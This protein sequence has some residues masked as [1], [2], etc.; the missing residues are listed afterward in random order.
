M[1][2]LGL[3][4]LLWLLAP[5]RPCLASRAPLHPHDGEATVADLVLSALERATAFL[6]RRLREVNLD[7][8]L[9]FRVLE[10]QLGGVREQWARDPGMRPLGLRAEK[11]AEELAGLLQGATRYLEQSDAQYLREFRPTLLPGFWRLPRVW[12]LTNASLAY[13]TLEKQDS[14]SE[15]QSDACLAQLLG[16]GVD[17]SQPCA[18]SDACASLMTRPGC[19]GYALSHQLLFFLMARMMGCTA[20]LFGQSQHYMNRFCAN[21]LLI[22]RRVEAGGYPPIARD[23]FCENI[24]FCGISG[25]LDFYRPGWLETILSWQQAPE[26][27]F[28]RAGEGA[29]ASPHS[30]AGR[31]SLRRVKRRDK[32]FTDGCSSHNTAV[33]VSAL[34][35]FLY[36]L[37][38]RPPAPGR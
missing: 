18:L 7:G 21:M 9:G 36:V 32:Q 10:V 31:H 28:G 4:L 8:V 1:S 17:S 25:F 20:G 16:T 26:G 13:P 24:M 37:A 30:P 33:A 12:T 35:G 34:G 3:L 23:I 14:F 38:A 15:E 19:T 27:C 22:N 29:A 2:Y 6:R 5:P 11:L